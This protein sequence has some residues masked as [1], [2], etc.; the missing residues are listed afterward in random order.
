[1]RHEITLAGNT[2]ILLSLIEPLT[3]NKEQAVPLKLSA[4][5]AFSR[6]GCHALSWL[7]PFLTM[8]AAHAC[9]AG[10]NQSVICWC[11]E[12]VGNH[13][14][15]LGMHSSPQG[16]ARGLDAPAS[17]RIHA[18]TARSQSHTD[19]GPAPLHL[20][21][22]RYGVTPARGLH[23]GPLTYNTTSRPRSFEIQNL[24]EFPFSF[25]LF[26]MPGADEAAA[27]GAAAQD[28]AGAAAQEGG[29]AKPAAPAGA[30]KGKLEKGE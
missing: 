25:R 19:T 10:P 14:H 8:F 11:M 13:A 22:D 16:V 7:R 15:M 30:A 12:S 23:F 6:W 1:M 27:A 29:P 20:C 2:D 4:H 26:A 5:A 24:G 28:G 17:A 18:M 9:T 21:L 3:A